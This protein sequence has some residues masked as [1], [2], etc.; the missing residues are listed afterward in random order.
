MNISPLVGIQKGF[1]GF[2]VLG[3]WGFVGPQ[4][5]GGKRGFDRVG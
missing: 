5:H 2:G 4:T 3:F 1:W